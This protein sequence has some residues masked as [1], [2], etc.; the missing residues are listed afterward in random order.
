MHPVTAE[1]KIGKEG[2]QYDLESYKPFCASYS[3]I[4]F[5]QFL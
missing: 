2:V 4:Q 3:L 1:A 5:A